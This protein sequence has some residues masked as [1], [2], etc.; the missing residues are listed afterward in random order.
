MM[1]GLEGSRWWKGDVEEVG[2][3]W[4]KA[5]EGVVILLKRGEVDFEWEWAVSVGVGLEWEV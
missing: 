2:V 3:D 1:G 5:E 4:V